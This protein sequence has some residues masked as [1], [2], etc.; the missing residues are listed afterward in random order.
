MLRLHLQEGLLFLRAIISGSNSNHDIPDIW[1]DQRRL[2]R[3]FFSCFNV[4]F[5][6]E[7]NYKDCSENN[8]SLLCLPVM[9]EADV[10]D[11]EAVEAK[12]S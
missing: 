9:S 7:V 12:S 4:L 5:H 2:A 6:Q 10:G 3:V 8:A 11:M 1:S